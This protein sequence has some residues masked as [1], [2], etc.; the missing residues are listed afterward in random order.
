MEPGKRKDKDDED[1]VFIGA[2]T[3]SGGAGPS[4]DEED[5]AQENFRSTRR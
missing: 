1:A 5:K 4:A 2:V 3:G